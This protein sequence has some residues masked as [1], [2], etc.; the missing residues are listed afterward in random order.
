MMGTQ[1]GGGVKVE[2]DSAEGKISRTPRRTIRPWGGL[3]M[4]TVYGT[5]VLSSFFL[6]HL[7]SKCGG[8]SQ[9]GYFVRL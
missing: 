3:I 1:S 9:F 8:N 2:P 5:C 4:D 6:L 7:R